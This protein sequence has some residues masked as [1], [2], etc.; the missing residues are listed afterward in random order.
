MPQDQK[1]IATKTTEGEVHLFD[2]YKHPK[3]PTSDE[4]KPDL[5]L[6]GHSQEGYGLTWNPLKKG[7]LLSGSDDCKLIIWDINAT[8]LNQQNQDGYLTYED[9]H[10][11]IIEDVCWN[12][13]D[14]NMFI[15][16]GDDKKFKVWDVRDSPSRP[17]FSV[18][19]HTQEIMS[20][21]QSPF[22]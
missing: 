16:C 3:E 22:D 14:E 7:V 20:V 9:A 18:E 13:F 2:Y 12:N 17:K 15:S 4:V 8:N 21:D 11:S 6:L 1:I 19:G 5:K 10:S